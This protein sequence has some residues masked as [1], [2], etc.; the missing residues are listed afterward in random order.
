MFVFVCGCASAVSVSRC[1]SLVIEF[2]GFLLRSFV[3]NVCVHVCSFFLC[4]MDH[5]N[6]E[7]KE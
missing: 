1:V 4:V 2:I 5:F 7:I 3:R 6:L